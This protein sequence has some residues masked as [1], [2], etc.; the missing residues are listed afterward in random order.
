MPVLTKS[1]KRVPLL[2]LHSFTLSIHSL[3][4]FLFLSFSSV[5][6]RFISS[7]PLGR[8]KSL[9]RSVTRLSLSLFSS[10]SLW[11]CLCNSR[12]MG[13]PSVF[14]KQTCLHTHSRKTH[15]TNQS[16]WDTRCTDFGCLVRLFE[17]NN[18]CKISYAT[19]YYCDQ[20]VKTFPFAVLNIF[21]KVK[22][23]GP[24]QVCVTLSISWKC[25]LI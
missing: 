1:V 25:H 18:L 14:A 8:S 22:H 12:E 4:F 6:S 20:F 11:V 9:R 16:L 21:D 5:G 23:C 10:L 24:Q 2:A 7:A 15:R 19:F 13:C 17:S 3:F